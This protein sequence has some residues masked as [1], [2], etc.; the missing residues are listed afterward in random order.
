[1]G[2]YGA[3]PAQVGEKARRVV[4]EVA[5]RH[6]LPIVLFERVELSMIDALMH[7]VTCHQYHEIAKKE[8]AERVNK[9]SLE[10]TVIST[11]C[12][13]R[14]RTTAHAHVSHNTATKFSHQRAQRFNTRFDIVQ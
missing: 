7:V 10:I 11:A 6:N 4:H 3:T 5:A 12:Q 1:M 2:R 13:W 14:T 9:V 8:D